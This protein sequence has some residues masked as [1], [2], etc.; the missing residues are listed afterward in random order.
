VAGGQRQAEVAHGRQRLGR[1]QLRLEAH[2]V[3]QRAEVLVGLEVIWLELLSQ[4]TLRSSTK[5][6]K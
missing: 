1:V 6:R 3:G 2:R 5:N 4:E